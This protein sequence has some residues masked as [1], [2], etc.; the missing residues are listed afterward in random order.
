MSLAVFAL[1]LS[2]LTTTLIGIGAWRVWRRR[3][4]KEK[5]KRSRAEAIEIRIAD[6][7]AIV[8]Q[9]NDDELSALVTSFGLAAARATSN[10]RRTNPTSPEILLRQAEAATKTFV[11]LPRSP[12]ARDSYMARMSD[13][14]DALTSPSSPQRPTGNEGNAATTSP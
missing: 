4:Q 2:P 11:N 13:L 14:L 7:R 8:A 9:Q 10:A 5:R 1:Y 3:G 12:N 6:M